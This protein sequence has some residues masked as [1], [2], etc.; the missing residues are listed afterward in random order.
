[1]VSSDHP[2][3]RL[4]RRGFTE[5]DS[6]S[7]RGSPGFLGRTCGEKMILRFLAG[8]GRCRL[9]PSH[10]LVRATLLVTFCAPVMAQA[11]FTEEALVRGVS[12]FTGGPTFGT[13]VAI[14]D[15]DNDGD[16]DLVTLGEI[17]GTIGIFENDGTGHFDR[18]PPDPG[19]PAMPDPSGVA[20]G[21]YDAD[22][23]LDVYVTAMSGTN[24]LLRND[25]Q[26][27]FTD[28]TA[29]A[30]VGDLEVGHGAAWADMDGDGLLDLFVS[31]YTQ[32][33]AGPSRL[34]RNMGNGTFV[35]ILDSC[36]IVDF[37][38]TF[39][40][41]FFDWDRDGDPDLYI[42]NDRCGVGQSN[43][44]WENV[45]GTFVDATDDSGCGACIFS[46]GLTI[47]DFDGDRLT[48]LYV[49]NLPYG[50]PLYLNQGDGTFLE[51]SDAAGVASY[52]TGW[53]TVFFDFDND[54]HQELYV[55]D[56]TAPNRLY[57]HDGV[58]PSQD[59]AADYGVTESARD[60]YGVAVG[61]LDLD[62]DLDLVVSN[63]NDRIRLFI[64]HEGETRRWVR[65]QV[66]G[67]GYNR[68]AIGAVAD[69]RTGTRWQTREIIAGS[70]FKSQNSLAL[71]YGLD[72][73]TT[74]DEVQVMWPGGDTRTLTQL[75]G[76]RTWT[77][78]PVEALGDGDLD[79]DVDIDDLA[80]LSGCQAA[81]TFEPGCEGLDLDGNG[82]VG[83]DDLVEFMRR[84]DGPFFDCDASGTMDSQD[85][86]GMNPGA[87]VPAGCTTFDPS[88]GG[89]PDGNVLP[90]Q[91][92]MI[93]KIPGGDLRL[94][95]GGVCGGGNS[96]YAVYGG[97]LGLFDSHMPVLCSTGGATTGTFKPG[98][99]DRYYLVVPNNGVREGSYGSASSGPR[100][101]GPATCHTQAVSTCP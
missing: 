57:N 17:P 100:D 78:Y 7:L 99:G 65:L 2:S 69:L 66:L 1:M 29:A 101:F 58:W 47:G 15:L 80:T 45:G 97:N 27:Q 76:N 95:W 85:I 11:P 37:G 87:G 61:D 59:L 24:F 22:G 5:P 8:L 98:A 53:G 71:H 21:D 30:G 93:D 25:G 9:T 13:G 50:N 82:N 12:Y 83:D 54:G 40:G 46:M 81:A 19:I 51:Y 70:N 14:A 4:G 68:F 90:G 39:Q 35:D 41:S 63:K 96:D 74:I 52:V 26:L 62:G 79:G 73:F 84:Y 36:G 88:M 43:R 72:G 89:V 18:M 10:L 91:P 86:V 77:I 34:Y 56:T 20:A 38:M 23:D 60:S 55:C 67:T 31:N 92:M 75:S 3:E 42:S 64:N 28:V 48:D 6:T 33:E 49:T 16:L 44:L 32:P 94:T